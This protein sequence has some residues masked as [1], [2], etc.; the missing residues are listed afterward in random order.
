[1]DALWGTLGL[2]L[3]LF[4]ATNIDD[5]FILIALFANPRFRPGQIVAGQLLG[6][7]VLIALSL[8]AAWLA[9]ALAP[10]WVGLLGFA[11][12]AL[13]LFELWERWRGE[14]DDDA[15]HAPG[16]HGGAVAAVTLIT[17]AN[18]GDNVALYVP[19]FAAQGAHEAALSAGLLLV[20]T[21]VWCAGARSLVEHA[22]LGGH[23]RRYV[24]PVTPFVLIG[25][26][27]YVL[28]DSGAWQLL[29]G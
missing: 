11:P 29:F 1:V 18:G 7:L 2:V 22:W 6:M 13:G 14:A 9:L 4:V 12:L 24:T 5:I 21:L 25:L 23:I 20:L 26:G 15:A 27:L 3:T 28:I 8:G 16:E 10:A 17:L 19:L